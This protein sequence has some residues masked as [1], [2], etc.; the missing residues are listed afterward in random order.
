VIGFKSKEICMLQRNE[1]GNFPSPAGGDWFQILF[2][3]S[4]DY[5][6]LIPPDAA[7]VKL[8]LRLFNHFVIFR[9]K[10]PVLLVRLS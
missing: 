4:L 3:G 8:L 5:P 1:K 6:G 7:L 10:T 2:A 9:R